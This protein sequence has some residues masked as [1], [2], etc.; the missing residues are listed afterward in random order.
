VRLRVLAMVSLCLHPPSPARVTRSL[1]ACKYACH[2]YKASGREQGAEGKKLHRA[3][4]CYRFTACPPKSW[5]ERASSTRR[6]A[7][8]LLV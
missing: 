8:Y 7:L 1:N 3:T 2:G 5:C 6:Y 4:G